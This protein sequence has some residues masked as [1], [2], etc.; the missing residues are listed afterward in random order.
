MVLILYYSPSSQE[1]WHYMPDGRTVRQDN[2][3]SETFKASGEKKLS[4]PMLNALTSEDGPLAPGALPAIKAAT[5]A[6]QKKLLQSL[7]E[8]KD[9]LKR[10]PEPPKEDAP[11]LEDVTP[12]T[13]KEP[14]SYFY[15]TQTHVLRTS[16]QIKKQVHHKCHPFERS[17][18]SNRRSCEVQSKHARCL[19]SSAREF[20]LC[21]GK[22]PK[23]V[24]GA[25]NCVRLNLLTSLL[26]SSCSMLPKWQVCT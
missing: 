17:Q 5:E 18:E 1:T 13:P 10:K 15:R 21:W 16:M 7:D 25:F 23:H 9:S 20:L 2:V 14:G 26:A 24:K 12:K 11:E 8:E 22:P 4:R 19:G 3:T 6:G